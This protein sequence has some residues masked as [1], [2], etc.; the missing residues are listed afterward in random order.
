MMKMV[1]SLIETVAM[2][3]FVSNGLN[4]SPTENDLLA[5]SFFSSAAVFMFMRL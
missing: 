2:E 3:I 5:L 1:W 4:R